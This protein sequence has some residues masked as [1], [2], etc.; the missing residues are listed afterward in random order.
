MKNLPVIIILAAILAACTNPTP[1]FQPIEVTRVVDVTR[2]VEVTKVI[3]VTRE[4]EVTQGVTPQAGPEIIFSGM[5]FPKECLKRQANIDY[6][7]YDWLN[8]KAIGGCSYMAPSPD[9]RY[10]AYSAITCLNSDTC[11][12]AVKI[13]ETGS[14]QAVTIQFMPNERK[15]WVASLGWSANGKLAVSY[16][17]INSGAGV[18]IFAEPF[19]E[20]P[21]PGEASVEGGIRQWNSARTAF[22]T[23]GATGEGNCD[24]LFSG[25][26]FNS[27]QAFPDIAAILGLEPLELNILPIDSSYTSTNWWDGDSQV[28]LLVTPLKYDEQKQDYQ[29]LPTMAGKITLSANGPEYTTLQSSSTENFYFTGDPGNFSVQPRP[30]EVKYCNE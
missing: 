14:E 9:G 22:I 18:Y 7:R 8:I 27:N 26:D 17:N 21:E 23:F 2:I 13:L 3:E 16:N 12:D 30:Y 4:A 6:W 29:F 24:T 5:V 28:L 11:G 19:L 20:N 15:K 25:F 10:L 1:D